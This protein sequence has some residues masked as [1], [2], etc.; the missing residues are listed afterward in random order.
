MNNLLTHASEN[1]YKIDKDVKTSCNS[2]KDRDGSLPSLDMVDGNDNQEKSAEEHLKMLRIENKGN[3][4]IGYLNINSLQNKFEALKALVEK[5]I[6]ILVLSETKIDESFPSN[7]FLIDSFSPPFRKDRDSQGGGILIYV[8]ENIPCR[9]L[10]YA[11]L[12]NDI[13]GIFIELSIDRNKWLMMGGYNPHKHCIS[14]FLNNISTII[15]LDIG[16]FEKFIFIADFNANSSNSSLIKFCDMYNLKNLI[17]EPTCYKNAENPSI[18]DLILTNCEHCFHHSSTIET[19][20]SDF[21]KMIITIMKSKFKKKEPLTINY[22]SYKNFNDTLFKCQLNA[23][24]NDTTDID[25]TYDHFKNTFIQLLDRHAPIKKKFVRGNNA[26]FMNKT[27]SQAFKHRSKLKNRYNKAPTEENHRAFKFQRNYC[28]SLLRREKK[29]YYNNLDT[30]IF[31]NNRKFWKSVKPLFSSKHIKST[32][33]IMLEEKA[34][35][36]TDKKEVAEMMNNF[37]IGAVDDLGIGPYIQN[38]TSTSLSNNIQNII[39]KYSEHPSVLKIKEKTTLGEKFAFQDA[40]CEDFEREIRKLDEKKANPQGDIPTNMIKAN[41]DV[42]SNYLCKIYNSAKEKQIYP[43]SL[44]LA[45]VIPIHKKEEK[46]L[47]KNYRPVSLVPTISKL[48]EKNMYHEIMQFIEKSLSPYLF[49]FRKGHSTEN[50]L[51]TM[52]EN[53]KKILDDKGYAGAILTD[54]SKAFDCINHELLLAKLDAYGF[55]SE[56]LNFMWSYLK[57][58]KQRTKIGSE[59]SK[60]LEIKYGVPQGSILGPLLFNIF[61]NDI[62]FFVQNIDIANFADDNTPY[63]TDK[64]LENLIKTLENETETLLNWFKINEMKPNED[65]C[66]LFVINKSKNTSAKVGNEILIGEKTVDLLGVKIDNELK[67]TEHITKLCKK[68]NQKFH[69]LARISSYLDRDKLKILM[70]TFITAQFNYCPLIWM[71]HNRT[72]NNKINR[73]HERSL[74]LVYKKDNLSFEE[75]LEL[76]QSVSIHHRNIQKLATEM[77]KVKNGLSPIPVKELFNECNSNYNLRNKRYWETSNAR[78]VIYGTETISFRGPKVWEMLPNDLKESQT[79]H[80]FKLKIKSW[81][82]DECDC[83]LCKTFIPNLGFI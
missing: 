17:H 79:L 14:Y 31:E 30:R 8:R 21:H 73:L 18:I 50:C 82:P 61:L 38:D 66:H 74:R 64:M 4:M 11:T 77:Y 68:G 44:K 62:F 12:P 36:I 81:K 35:L 26:P 7:Q 15:D 56:A 42:V 27:L 19:G 25:V 13:E 45:D 41:S 3:L 53:W 43:D 52:L 29:K 58:R 67:F 47:V 55:S 10:N 78:T 16:K 46:T 9:L 71:F 33:E 60:W 2:S 39:E 1:K 83:R 76:D 51:L 40:T 70:K 23:T 24:L 75:L 57:D 48:F 54:L 22:R 28:V 65:K 34:K 69:A 37:F 63:G 20:L 32:N 5:N 72:L 59:F 80:E 49:G 6:D